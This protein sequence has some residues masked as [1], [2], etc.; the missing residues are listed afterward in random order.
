M[1][2]A[3]WYKKICVTKSL[4]KVKH[5]QKTERFF[6]IWEMGK[7]E[8]AQDVAPP[9]G[10]DCESSAGF[11]K[12]LQLVGGHNRFQWM[13][14]CVVSLQLM[15][16]TWNHMG[17]IFIGAVPDHWCHL[18]QLDN[19]SW[20]VE[21]IRNISIPKIYPYALKILWYT[22]WNAI[23]NLENTLENIFF[24]RD[25]NSVT[26]KYDQCQY[27]SL[28]YAHLLEQSGGDFQQAYQLT[29][30][31]HNDTEKLLKRSCHSWSYDVS[32]YS[33]T[34]ASEVGTLK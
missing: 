7:I 25:E 20:S 10:V 22:F 12:A 27:Y 30:G 17:Y 23:K 15:L 21:Q 24:E 4:A 34:I 13:A 28:D 6:F 1:H 8:S 3:I 29:H 19:T 9:S 26:F 5:K 33:L 32:I 18:E 2:H 14:M 11:E 31:G 16:L